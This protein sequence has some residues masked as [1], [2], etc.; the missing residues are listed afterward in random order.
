MRKQYVIVAAALFLAWGCDQQAGKQAESQSTRKDSVRYYEWKPDTTK[1]KEQPPIIG[2]RINGPANIRNIA[3]GDVVFSLNDNTL[4]TCTEQQHGWYQVGLTMDLPDDAFG[5]GDLKKGQ[6][7][8]VNG[9][10]VGEILKD[11]H[12]ST[13]RDNKRTWGELIGFTHANN[14]YPNTIIENAFLHW[15]D[16][17]KDR[18]QDA[19]KPFIKR[20]KLE[21]D[22]KEFA[23]Y[24]INYNYENWIN[25]PSAG[26]RLMLVFHNKRLIGVFNTRPITLP[27][28]SHYALERGFS[29]EFYNDVAKE[30]RDDFMHQMS[31]FLL[32]AD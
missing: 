24:V 11:M 14:I 17:T 28:A 16:S 32:S 9:K 19:L 25:D 5:E 27:A 21:E 23:P 1:P 12:V 31:Q 15:M 10:V 26:Y 7:I 8:K 29:V 6:Q 18:T 3:N 13:S 2:E 30:V 4:V 22:H 20:F